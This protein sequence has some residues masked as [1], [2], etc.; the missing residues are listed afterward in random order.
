MAE[1]APLA[2][3][4]EEQ[5]SLTSLLTQNGSQIGLESFKNLCKLGCIDQELGGLFVFLCS[6]SK[7]TLESGESINLR[8][9]D[10]KET[11]MGGFEQNDLEEIAQIAE[12]LRAE[13]ER[14]RQT[15]LVRQLVHDGDI[16][17]GDLLNRSPLSDIKEVRFDGLLMLPDVLRK[18]GARQRPEYTRLLTGI[19]AHIYEHT[20]GWHDKCV[21]DVLNDLSPDRKDPYTE[22]GLKQWRTR[23][24]LKGQEKK[25]NL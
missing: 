8:P 5:K 4:K 21:A 22:E 18:C 16:K 2:K 24:G 25:E 13:C 11:A 17:V 7:I 6:P 14:L 1:A 10:S 12:R 15:P 19:F 23:Q 20:K 9:L 3:A